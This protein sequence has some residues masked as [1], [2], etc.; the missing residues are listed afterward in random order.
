[1][2]FIKCIKEFC[3]IIWHTFLNC[4]L[5]GALSQNRR[6]FTTVLFVANITYNIDLKRATELFLSN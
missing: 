6:E 5:E 3:N 2:I 1:M 4:K